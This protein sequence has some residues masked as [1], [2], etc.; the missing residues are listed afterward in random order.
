MG[1]LIK[2]TC[3]LDESKYILSTNKKVRYQSGVVSLLYILKHS[4]LD[5]NNSVR[6]LSKS[7]DREENEG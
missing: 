3:P 1:N 7:M 2:V 6:E 5:L 4:R